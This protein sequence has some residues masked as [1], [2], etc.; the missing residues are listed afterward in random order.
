MT[1]DPTKAALWTGADVYI[2]QLASAEPTDLT[3]PWAVD[4][5]S[6]GLLDG[7]AG[8]TMARAEDTN[9]FFGWGG[10][11]I[12]RTRSNH[13]RT[14]QFTALE[15]NDTVFDLVNPGSTRTPGVAGAPTISKIK[16][17][18]TRDFAIG[19]ELRDGAKVKRRMVKRATVSEIGEVVEA[20]SA[21]TVYTITVTLYP[22]ADGNLYTELSA[23]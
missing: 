2:A 20:E 5:E 22:E 13:Q 17:P 18:Q 11:L 14:I 15:D 23:A 3:T 6:A 16:V 7:E 4:W 10:I 8:F 12:R 1:G 19:F 21:L 9:E